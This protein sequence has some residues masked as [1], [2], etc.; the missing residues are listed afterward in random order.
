MIIC[1]RGPSPTQNQWLNIHTVIFLS[2]NSSE[3][4]MGVK[5]NRWLWFMKIPRHHNSFHILAT[6]PR[7][8]SSSRWLIWPNHYH[9]HS[10]MQDS[11]RIRLKILKMDKE[12]AY[13]ITTLVSE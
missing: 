7:G 10:R 1:L 3:V 2:H 13:I 6:N 12:I 11:K 5:V 8:L 4:D 9:L